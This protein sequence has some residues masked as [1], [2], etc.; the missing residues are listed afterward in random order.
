[1]S[2][3]AYG[4]KSPVR[5][6][7]FPSLHFQEGLST[8]RHP[9]FLSRAIHAR[10]NPSSLEGGSGLLAVHEP[11]SGNVW[12]TFKLF[13]RPGGRSP[14]R[15]GLSSQSL[16]VCV[17][18]IRPSARRAVAMIRVPGGAST[19]RISG[20]RA[21]PRRAAHHLGCRAA[22]LRRQR[23]HRRD[24]GWPIS[25]APASPPPSPCLSAGRRARHRAGLLPQSRG[26]QAHCLSVR[27]HGTRAQEAGRRPACASSRE[28]AARRGSLR[29]TRRQLEQRL[30]IRATLKTRI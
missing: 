1:M 11:L 14:R 2:G 13:P 6:T 7:L 26:R 10:N 21:A 24:H 20:G 28:S 3:G 27:L 29:R 19:P 4:G 30:D 12:V 5:G 23:S 25:R 8:N 9:P 16:E 18:A 15:Y 17:Q 22:P